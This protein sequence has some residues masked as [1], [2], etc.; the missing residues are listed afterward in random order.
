M[1]RMKDFARWLTGCIYHC[2]M[3]DGAIR[4]AYES[5]IGQSIRKEDA[6][7]L[8]N[9]IRIVRNNPEKYRDLTS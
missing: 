3:S 7:W 4:Q 8:N 1:S 2:E 9:Q 5:Y 6:Q